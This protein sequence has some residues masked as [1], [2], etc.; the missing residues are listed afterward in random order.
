[1]VVLKRYVVLLQRVAACAAKEPCMC[2]RLVA[3]MD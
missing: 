2:M 1:M 3:V